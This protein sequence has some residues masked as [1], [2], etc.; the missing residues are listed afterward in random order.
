MIESKINI[1]GNKNAFPRKYVDNIVIPFTPTQI[2]AMINDDTGIQNTDIHTTFKVGCGG[3]LG[4]IPEDVSRSYV[5]E[6][7]LIKGW[8]GKQWVCINELIDRESRWDNT[9]DNPKSSAYGL[10]QML[11]TP[12]GLPMERQTE[13][14]LRYIEH[15]YE[16]PCEALKHHNRKNWY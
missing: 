9:A 11:K 14:G 3:V 16:T 4:K 2:N 15:R 6:Q 5:R 8:D 12:N 10:F 7:D 13:R 1:E